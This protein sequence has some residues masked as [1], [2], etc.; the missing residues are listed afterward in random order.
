MPPNY[1]PT[2]RVYIVRHGNGTDYSKVQIN[3]VYLEYDPKVMANSVFVLKIRHEK[4]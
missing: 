1:T 4:F 2:Y 3:E